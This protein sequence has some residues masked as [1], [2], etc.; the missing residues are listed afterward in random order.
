MRPPDINDSFYYEITFE[1]N[2]LEGFLDRFSVLEIV[3]IG[4][5]QRNEMFRGSPGESSHRKNEPFRLYFACE[6]VWRKDD[7]S[8]SGTASHEND[9]SHRD[10]GRFGCLPPRVIANWNLMGVRKMRHY[11][12]PTFV[13]D[14]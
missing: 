1:F 13:F 7:G 8:N 6:W 12:E 5:R 9:A 14:D 11:P 2:N 10:C 4:L 3:R